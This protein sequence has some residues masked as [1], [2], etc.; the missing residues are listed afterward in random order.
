MYE[1][2]ISGLLAHHLV[3]NIFSVHIPTGEKH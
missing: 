3:Y 2:R 1:I